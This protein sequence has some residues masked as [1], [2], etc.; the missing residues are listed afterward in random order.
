[1]I[2]YPWTFPVSRF[3]MRILP[4]TRV[5]TGPYTPTTQT[6]DLLGERLMV[7]MDL[8]PSNDSI[9]GAKREA[10]F[11]RLK[12]SANLITIGHQKLKAPQ[13]TLRGSTAVTWLSGGSPATWLSGGSAATWIGG[14]PVLAA[15]IA[16]LA[17][18][19]TVNCRAGYTLLAGDWF[20]LGGQL[21][22]SMTNTVADGSGNMP[23]EFQPR[24][25]QTIAA[26]TP[27]L[28]DA[29]TANFILK[30]GT[31]NVPTSWTPGMVDGATIELIEVF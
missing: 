30:P 19:G 4:N 23:I 20:G 2:F 18:T 25:R 10:F 22:Q 6:L 11:N 21:V 8:P 12:G 5:F 1:V 31:L 13:G 17:S 3:E 9:E 14:A 7:S 29:P 27:I 28:W 26:G 15:P 16:Q 24:A